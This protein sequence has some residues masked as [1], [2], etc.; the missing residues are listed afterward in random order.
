ML[1][2]PLQPSP[3]LRLSVDVP[4]GLTVVVIAAAAAGMNDSASSDEVI[5]RIAMSRMST[6]PTNPKEA[7]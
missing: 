1:Q 2:S 4:I 6:W 5:G 7:G 3:P